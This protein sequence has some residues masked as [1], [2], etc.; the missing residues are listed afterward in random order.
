M[1]ANR[2]QDVPSQEEVQGILCAVEQALAGAIR[3]QGGDKGDKANKEENETDNSNQE[4]EED[5]TVE[6]STRT[7][8]GGRT[9]RGIDRGRAS[10]RRPTAT[11]GGDRPLHGLKR[12]LISI[13]PLVTHLRT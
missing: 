10:G 1:A 7:S 12:H 13:F 6:E 2:G 11:E 9:M 5:E 3:T 4:N 8:Q